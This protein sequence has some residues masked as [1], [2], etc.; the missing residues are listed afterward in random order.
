MTTAI[1]FLFAEMGRW[2]RGWREKGPWSLVLLALVA[3]AGLG[4]LLEVLSKEAPRLEHLEGI[5][6]LSLRGEYQLNSLDQFIV[7]HSGPDE[8]VL[9]WGNHPGINF[10]TGRRYPARYPFAMHL[11]TPSGEGES[12]FDQ[13]L[14]DIYRDPPALILAQPQSS[15]GIPY[16]GQEGEDPCPD[17][18][19][20]A[21]QGLEELGEYVAAFYTPV[22]QIGEWLIFA[23]DPE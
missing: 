15:A 14:Q 16:F 11:I 18:P 23:R 21:R 6:R 20:E 2:L 3:A 1:A 13:F 4:W 10:R 17:C 19:P 8:S 7:D 22:E 12:R 9:V 5:A